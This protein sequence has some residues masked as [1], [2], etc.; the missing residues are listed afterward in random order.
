MRHTIQQYHH[1][2]ISIPL[3]DSLQFPEHVSNIHVLFLDPKRL[4]KVSHQFQASDARYKSDSPTWGQAMPKILF[5]PFLATALECVLLITAR[6]RECK[7]IFEYAGYKCLSSNQ[8]VRVLYL[9][10][11]ILISFVVFKDLE[12][13]VVQHN[14]RNPC[15]HTSRVQAQFPGEGVSNSS[16]RGF[17]RSQF[18][19]VFLPNHFQSC[20]IAS[21]VLCKQ[22]PE[23]FVEGS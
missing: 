15:N 22:R 23:I 2:R 9:F 20:P 12:A 6:T 3:E 5:N 16:T 14:F 11:L 13:G 21:A 4:E 18:P 8:I 17:N 7:L 10:L 1:P 19:A